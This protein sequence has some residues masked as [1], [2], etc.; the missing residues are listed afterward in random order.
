MTT[1]CSSR[2]STAAEDYPTMAEFLEQTGFSTTDDSRSGS[3]TSGSSP[4]IHR[5][6]IGNPAGDADSIISS[7]GCAYMDTVLKHTPTVPVLSIP[8]SDL[9]ALRP[10]TK[11]LLSLAGV[12]NLNSLHSI[13]SNS[14]G[15]SS[16]STDDTTAVPNTAV[17]TL[18]D[19]NQLAIASSKN[20]NYNHKEWKVETIL[21]HHVDEGAHQD[22]CIERVIAFDSL[23]SQALVASTCT[24]LVERWQHFTANGSSC[25]PMPP[26]LAILLLGVIL[27]DSINLQHKAGKVTP[28]DENAVTFL[29]DTTD[30]SQLQLPHDIIASD[31]NSSSPDNTKL[32]ETLQSQKFQASF[33]NDL[34][35]SQALQLD[36]KSFT[37]G[38][39]QPHHFGI[40]SVLQSMA[41]FLQK[42]DS[43]QSLVESYFP[44][45]D[46]VAVMFLKIEHDTPQRELLLA[47]PDV[48]LMEALVQHLQSE[49]DGSS[50]LQP[51]ILDRYWDA[52][53]SLHCVQ[54]KQGNPKASRKQVAPVLI[55][56]YKKLP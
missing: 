55:E 43:Y 16:S 52:T 15:G 10:E 3:T 28:R 34:T 22:T 1:L 12:R 37:V 30:W 38:N 6:A 23:S 5:L 14:S 17:V 46:F 31:R 56:F 7:M 9:Q 13:S 32:F 19:H 48:T 54:I 29:R 35:A 4:A 24:L 50:I 45:C 41:E 51:I 8:I 26:T 27:I 36:Y 44:R 11:Y 20:D 39:E 49:D 53:T 2:S 47:C 18:V 25:S 40:A 33:W 42:P 21:D